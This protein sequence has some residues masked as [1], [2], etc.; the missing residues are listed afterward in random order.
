MTFEEWWDEVGHN[1]WCDNDDIF[2]SDLVKAAWDAA[3]EQSQ[4]KVEGLENLIIVN[5]TGDIVDLYFL[6]D[7]KYPL[8]LLKQMSQEEE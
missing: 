6:L 1:M 5:W 8:G 4:L 2:L 3:M 7:E